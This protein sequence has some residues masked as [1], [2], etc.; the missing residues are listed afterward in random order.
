MLSRFSTWRIC[1]HEQAKS[2]CDWLVMSSVFV[3]SQSSCFFLCL[4][5]QI[6]L[7]ENRLYEV[8][9]RLLCLKYTTCASILLLTIW[10]MH[11]QKKKTNKVIS[12]WLNY[13]IF[14]VYRTAKTM[15]ENF[16][17]KFLCSFILHI[18]VFLKPVFH[19]A[20]LFARTSKK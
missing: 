10:Y 1:S 14:V 5:E 12:L 18:D 16:D 3:A 13:S 6:L 4:R 15:K 19:L 7:V 8:H 2:E 11:I 9:N 20:N 17:W